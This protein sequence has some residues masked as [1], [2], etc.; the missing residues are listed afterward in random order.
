MITSV[1][2]SQTESSLKYLQMDRQG[3][4]QIDRDPSVLCRTPNTVSD[5]M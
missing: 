5:S 1:Y 4:P 2:D 3:G